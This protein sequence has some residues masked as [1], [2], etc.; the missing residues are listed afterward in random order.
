M[1]YPHKASAFAGLAAGILLVTGL[2]PISATATVA[3]DEMTIAHQEAAGGHCV[4]AGTDPPVVRCT[5]PVGGG[6][7][8]PPWLQEPAQIQSH[9]LL[10]PGQGGK[11]RLS[12]K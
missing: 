9:I 3:A 12:I 5:C 7:E 2:G 8:I 4:W 1:F 6:I 11:T 10:I